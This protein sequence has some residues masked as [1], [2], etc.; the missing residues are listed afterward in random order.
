MLKLNEPVLV[1]P[2]ETKIL[3]K[4]HLFYSTKT[5]KTS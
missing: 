3:A 5:A 1:G 4:I 2:T